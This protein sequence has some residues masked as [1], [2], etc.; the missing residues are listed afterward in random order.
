MNKI[1]PKKVELS[2][3]FY[4]LVFVYAI[5]RLTTFLD[6]PSLH[7]PIIQLLTF[8][9]VTIVFI[10]IWMVETVYTNRFGRNSVADISLFMLSMAILLFMSNTFSGALTI[11]FHPFALSAAGLSIIQVLQY[12]MA[13]I[14]AEN[15]NDRQLSHIFIVILT[16]RAVL[17][18]LGSLLPLNWGVPLAISGILISWIM[19]GLFRSIMTSHPINFPHLIERLTSLIIIMFGEMIV[20]ISGYFTLK[21]LN[22]TSILIFLIVCSLFM[23]Y[24]TQF[25]HYLDSERG[26]ET[27]V[28]MIYL[29]YFILFG[30]M[31]VTSALSFIGNLE[32]TVPVLISF[33][34]TGLLLF[35]LGLFLASP[36][37]KVHLQLPY[38]MI[39]LFILTTVSGGVFSYL[40]LKTNYIM[41]IT[42][43]L[44]FINS[45]IFSA[46]MI[47]QNKINNY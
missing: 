41:V 32:I 25:D 43:A 26:Q 24:I 16:L 20:D 38:W 42:A 44:T 11:W 37:N 14:H 3:L 9:I 34:Y 47:R 10:N 33:L 6:E 45:F 27:G 18:L 35:Y 28:A 29:H 13:Y 5:S 1:V 12:G 17:L 4:D 46:Y 23:T 22:V 2:E 15:N 21:T 39:L 19:P 31:L 40:V 7:S 30:L 36:F 8:S